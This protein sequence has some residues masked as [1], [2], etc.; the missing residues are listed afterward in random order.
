MKKRKGAKKEENFEKKT[1][2]IRRRK[3]TG[4]NCHDLQGLQKNSFSQKKRRRKR[5]KGHNIRKWGS[6][7]KKGHN[8]GKWPKTIASRPLAGAISLRS[9]K[10]QLSTAFSPFGQNIS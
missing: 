5:K 7:E 2:I 8:I 1:E 10:C 6:K 3:K 9:T 4:T